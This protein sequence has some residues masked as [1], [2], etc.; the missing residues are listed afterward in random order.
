[1]G[2]SWTEEYY[3]LQDGTKVP[4]LG[5]GCYNPRK[6]D[7]VKVIRDAV[8]TG[9]RYF[10]TASFYETE[11]DLAKALKETGISRGEVQ[12]ASK[13]WHDEL[14]Y[15]ETRAAFN[16]TLERLET[17]YLDFYLIHWPKPSEEDP[18]WKERDLES[19]KAIAQLKKEGKIRHVGMSNFLPHHLENIMEG[20]DCMPEVDQLELHIGYSQEAAAAYCKEKGLLVQAWGPLGRGRVNDNA[21]ING[22][23]KK[24]GKT[25]TQISLRFLLQKG[26]M[27]IPKSASREHMLENTRVF[28]FE[29][30]REDMWMLTCM[31]QETWQGEHPDFAIPKKYSNFAQ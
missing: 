14:G 22:M 12:I 27:P 4:K 15:E 21:I 29:I 9:Y 28:D 7:Y 20:S 3:T 25:F 17:D 11:R 2:T 8:E 30:S 31:P 24:Y 1:M 6:E 16:R 13:A 19:W 23:A 10:D 26:I 5:F 18:D